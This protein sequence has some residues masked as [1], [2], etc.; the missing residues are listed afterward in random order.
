LEMTELVVAAAAL[1]ELL[2]KL[3]NYR[4]RAPS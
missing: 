1:Q 2:E 4:K 3:K